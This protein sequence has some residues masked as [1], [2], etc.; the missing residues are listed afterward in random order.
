MNVLSQQY[1]CCPDRGRCCAQGLTCNPDADGETCLIPKGR[2]WWWTVARPCSSQDGRTKNSAGRN[3]VEVENLKQNQILNRANTHIHLFAQQ[4]AEWRV[5]KEGY[6][7]SYFAIFIG[8]SH[9]SHQQELVYVYLF[10]LLLR[11][12]FSCLNFSGF[13][14]ILFCSVLFK[15]CSIFFSVLNGKEGHS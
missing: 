15:H 12:Q 7:S 13:A 2:L 3:Q 9:S 10:L 1:Q 14:K 4:L 5:R 11:W 8:F 6:H